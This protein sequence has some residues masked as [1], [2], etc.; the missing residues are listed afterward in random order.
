MR[1]RSDSDRGGDPP[2]VL[3]TRTS[4]RA[5]SSLFAAPPALAAPRVRA[6]EEA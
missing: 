3:R 2:V 5:A 6:L 4:V 1:A